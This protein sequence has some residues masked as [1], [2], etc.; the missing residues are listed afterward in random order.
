MGSA[1]DGGVVAMTVDLLLQAN[2]TLP[3][4]TEGHM[5]TICFLKPFQFQHAFY[6]IYIWMYMSFFA[7]IFDELL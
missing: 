2:T 6:H 1:S 7:A 5:L 3:S 4:V